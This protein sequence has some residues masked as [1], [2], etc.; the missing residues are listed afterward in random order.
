MTEDEAET[1]ASLAAQCA[2]GGRS[3]WDLMMRYGRLFTPGTDVGSGFPMIPAWAGRNAYQ[4]AMNSGLLYTEG[5][6]IRGVQKLLKDRG[7]RAVVSGDTPPPDA[8]EAPIAA[9]SGS[10]S[11]SQ[12]AAIRAIRD[13]LASALGDGAR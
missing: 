10:L 6:T 1:V 13:R 12:I 9:P 11:P 5:Y 2:W 7:L 8:Q 4:R 3:S